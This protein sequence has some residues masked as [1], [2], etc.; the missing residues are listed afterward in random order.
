[1]T[2]EKEAPLKFATHETSHGILIK[3]SGSTESF[4]FDKDLA[5][6]LGIGEEKRHHITA[7]SVFIPKLNSPGF[8]YIY[9]DLVDTHN[10]LHDGKPSK[11]LETLSIAGKAYEKVTDHRPN[12]FLTL[13][14]KPLQYVSSVTVTVKDETGSLFDFKGQPLHFKLEIN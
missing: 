1:M 5:N 7:E 8:Y 4:T 13:R 12:Y 14:A 6:I 10:N 3:K 2:S 9:C 11:L